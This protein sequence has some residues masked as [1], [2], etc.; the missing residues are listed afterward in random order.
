MLISNVI[1]GL[2]MFI[3]VMTSL[4]FCLSLVFI[5]IHDVIPLWEKKGV[6]QLAL[7][8]NFQVA[9]ETCNSPYLYVV[10]DIKQVA[11]VARVATHCIYGATH[12]NLIT[13][14]L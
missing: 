7:Q 10:S 5:V 14:L 8:L 12:Y 1:V 4:G 6:L 11:K 2:C 13:I 9:L 3:H